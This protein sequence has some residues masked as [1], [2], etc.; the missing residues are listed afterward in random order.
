MT[1]RSS[2]RQWRFLPKP[3]PEV[4]RLLRRSRSQQEF[5]DLRRIEAKCKDE[6]RR[7]RIE[8]VK[9]L[10]E[11]KS[12]VSWLR[13]E[14]HAIQKQWGQILQREE[15]AARKVLPRERIE[16]DPL[17]KRPTIP[18][19]HEL[20]DTARSIS[21]HSEQIGVLRR[22]MEQWDELKVPPTGPWDPRW[23]SFCTQ[24][25][26]EIELP[27][28]EE[29]D[30]YK[31]KKKAIEMQKEQEEKTIEE[32]PVRAQ[33]KISRLRHMVEELEASSRTAIGEE[34]TSGEEEEASESSDS[35]RRYRRYTD[36][37]GNNF[38]LRGVKEDLLEAFGDAPM[39]ERILEN[40]V[41]QRTTW[42]R[43]GTIY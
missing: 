19:I 13:S 5:R 43:R 25:R 38:F 10:R 31:E 34:T 27:L 15:R 17:W 6:L 30:L 1:K 4:Q 9:E 39:V 21:V 24:W 42:P 22:T 29:Q 20:Q 28:S 11:S 16:N 26:N 7:Q 40:D 41:V 14:A 18:M 33:E 12:E 37:S 8:H 36:S 3:R 2:Y 23:T 35:A 32:V